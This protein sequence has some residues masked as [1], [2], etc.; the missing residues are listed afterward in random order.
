MNLEMGGCPR[1]PPHPTTRAR[2]SLTHDPHT[3]PQQERGD[4]GGERER[5]GEREEM[6]ISWTRVPVW[7]AFERIA[8]RFWPGLLEPDCS[9]CLRPCAPSWTGGLTPMHGSCGLLVAAFS[10]P[11]KIERTHPSGSPRAPSPMHFRGEGRQ[12]RER[13]RGAD[14]PT[15]WRWPH[16]QEL[17]PRAESEPRVEKCACKL[18]LICVSLFLSLATVNSRQAA[19]RGG[20]QRRRVA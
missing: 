3:S 7:R 6:S 2:D 1:S 20:A 17:N 18:L 11:D 14:G 4:R 9:S 13:F 15:A 12:H 8:R 10:K 5:E 16:Q 19:F